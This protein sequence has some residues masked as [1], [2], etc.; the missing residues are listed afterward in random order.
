MGRVITVVFYSVS[1]IQMVWEAFEVTDWI[2]SH[3]TA[4]NRKICVR[5]QKLILLTRGDLQAISHEETLFAQQR[6]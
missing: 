2:I 3:A 6:V 1:S 4:R 5:K